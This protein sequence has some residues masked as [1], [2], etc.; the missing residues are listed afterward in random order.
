MTEDTTTLPDLTRKIACI[1][2]SAQE[3]DLCANF[4]STPVQHTIPIFFSTHNIAADT[5]NY[6]AV[7]G[8]N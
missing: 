4:F 6:E 3:V 7:I 5:C 2:F 1:N 8:S